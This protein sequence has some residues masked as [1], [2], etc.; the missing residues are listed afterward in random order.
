MTLEELLVTINESTNVNVY[1]LEKQKIAHYDGKNS[2]PQ[3]YN[4]TEVNSVDVKDN[5]LEVIVYVESEPEMEAIVY[6]HGKNDYSVW[7][8]DLPKEAI[9]EIEN[10]LNQYSHRGCSIRGSVD[11]LVKECKNTE[12]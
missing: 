7:Q 11:D 3:K 5:S 4:N 8:L 1:N 6:K 12:L 2:I 9:M 10:I